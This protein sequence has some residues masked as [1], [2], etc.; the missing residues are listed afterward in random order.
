MQPLRDLETQSSKR[1]GACLVD[2]TRTNRREAPRAEFVEPHLQR[3]WRW[4]S[5]V[6]DECE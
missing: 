3:G 6:I 5:A 2:R 4:H 1:V